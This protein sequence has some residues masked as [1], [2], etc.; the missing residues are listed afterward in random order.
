M[1]MKRAPR[2]WAALGYLP[3]VFGLLLLGKVRD[4]FIFFHARQALWV[5]L[6]FV[7]A[8]AMALLPGT[9]FALIKWPV[10]I[11]AALIFAFLL[12]RGLVDALTGK[13]TP[14]PP[15]GDYV[16][17]RDFLRSLRRG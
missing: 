2:L 4:S 14:L 13:F 8:L 11:T 16:Q 10:A 5:W 12:I 1:E 9:F 3:P 6:L 7:L 17:K 15:F